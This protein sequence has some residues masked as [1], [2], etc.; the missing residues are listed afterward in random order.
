MYDYG[1]ETLKDA[2][3]T[4]NTNIKHVKFI[5]ISVLLTVVV[6][7]LCN[8]RNRCLLT[9]TDINRRKAE[10]KRSTFACFFFFFFFSFVEFN[11]S[12]YSVKVPLICVMKGS[13]FGFGS[14]Q[15]QVDIQ[16]LICLDWSHFHFILLVMPDKA[17]FVSAVLLCLRYQGNGYCTSPKVTPS[18]KEW[19]SSFIQTKTKRPTSGR[20]IC[21][22]FMLNI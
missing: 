16:G 18:G 2:T 20:A 14:P 19:I 1:N 6:G 12:A 13:Y 17:A 7:G 9:Q 4:L 22:Y 5:E 10:K 8:V 3:Y 15:Q 11:D 21:Q